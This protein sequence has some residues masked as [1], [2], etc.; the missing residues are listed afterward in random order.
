MASLKPN[1]VS[2]RFTVFVE[3]NSDHTL[4]RLWYETQLN[5]GPYE[6]KSYWSKLSFFSLGLRRA[7]IW[8]ADKTPCVN[9]ALHIFVIVCARYE[10]RCFISKVDFSIPG[11]VFPWRLDD[12][13]GNLIR[14]YR[15]EVI[16]D[17]HMSIFN[18]CSRWVPW[19]SWGR[20]FRLS[21]PAY[22][23]TT[24]RPT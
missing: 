5:I 19:V 15:R 11:R 17:W 24:I 6:S 8:D 13:H 23:T 2:R 20:L 4:D 7:W 18:N 1:V 21:A 3:T 14:C 10:L 22:T 16:Q 12:D 9:D